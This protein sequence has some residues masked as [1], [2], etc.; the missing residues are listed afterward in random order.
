ML[1]T[2][3][4]LDAENALQRVFARCRA[5][6]VCLQRFGDPEQ[7]Y[8]DLRSKLE[9]AA[10]PVELAEPRSGK[11]LQIEF[12]SQMLGGALR[13]AGYSSDQAALLPLGCIWP[14]A[15]PVRAAGI[16]FLMMPPVTIP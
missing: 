7:D 3:T 4:P 13:L 2:S 5:Q 8:L 14:T 10:V 1:G 15:R 12:S 16:A 6:P 9:A 11:P